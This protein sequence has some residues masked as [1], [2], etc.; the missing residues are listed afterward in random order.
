MLNLKALFLI[1]VFSLISCESFRE[2][3]LKDHANDKAMAEMFGWFDGNCFAIASKSLS[4][5]T[6][7]FVV[8]L[9]SPQSISSV[10]VVG[11]ANEQRC[12]PLSPDRRAQNISEGLSFYEV[13]PDDGIGLAIGVIGEISQPKTREGVVQADLGN[14]GTFERFTLCATNE[15]LSFDIWT[16]TPY[17][18]EPIWSGYY[19]LGYDVERTC[20]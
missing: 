1:A 10:K 19:Y 20:P 3:S 2:S 14:D 7:I 5:G 18:H 9:D 6:E 17:E 12:G 15:G 8:T 11:S 16:S 4:P 13:K